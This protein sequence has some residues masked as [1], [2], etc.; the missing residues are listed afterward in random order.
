MLPRFAAAV[1]RNDKENI[2]RIKII[3]GEYACNPENYSLTKTAEEVYRIGN[4]PLD[5]EDAEIVEN[6]KA[7]WIESSS[8]AER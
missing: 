8:G 1:Q 3:I 2:E 5:Q 6:M 7:Y 4:R